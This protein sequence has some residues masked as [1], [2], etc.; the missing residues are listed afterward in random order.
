MFK[1]KFKLDEQ[2]TRLSWLHVVVVLMPKSN[3]QKSATLVIVENKEK[4]YKLLNDPV[5]AVCL[6]KLLFDMV[7]EGWRN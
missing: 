1:F 2:T 7:V 6:Q 3:S 5:Q 4:L